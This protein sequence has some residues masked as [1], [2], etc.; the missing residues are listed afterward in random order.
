LKAKVGETVRIYFGNIGPNSISFFYIIGEIFDKVYNHGG[1]GG[2]IGKNIQT[3]LVPC[4]GA[5]IVEFKV[6]APDYY[7]LVA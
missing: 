6:D 4:A 3:T 7:A 5:T 1:I 2:S